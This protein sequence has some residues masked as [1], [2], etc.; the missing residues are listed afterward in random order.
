MDVREPAPE[1]AP[2]AGGAETLV[3]IAAPA[4]RMPVRG[5]QVAVP[6]HVPVAQELVQDAPV[7]QGLVRD[8]PE[9]ALISAPGV[10]VAA[11]L[12]SVLV[13]EVAETLAVCVV[14]AVHLVVME[15][16][17]EVVQLLVWV[18]AEVQVNN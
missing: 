8:A 12:A 14:A 10:L 5:V 16:V 18:V 11:G 7:V 17:T 4:A 15:G 6:G 2:G 3:V 1:A 13:S 9:L